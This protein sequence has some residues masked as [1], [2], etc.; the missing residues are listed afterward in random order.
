MNI[1]F[2]VDFEG[3]NEVSFDIEHEPT[4]PDEFEQILKTIKSLI[5][6]FRDL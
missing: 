3:K 5:G 4:S 6:V 1:N 2:H